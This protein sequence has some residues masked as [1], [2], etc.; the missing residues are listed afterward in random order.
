MADTVLVAFGLLGTILFV[1]F[2]GE[3]VFRKF[4]IPGVLLLL[5]TGFLLS[6]GG[7]QYVDPSFD[8]A[9]LASYRTLLGP[10]TLMVIL[11][12]GGMLLNIYTVI[13]QSV[14]PF[15]FGL[16]IVL[17][18]AGATALIAHYLFR[19]DMMAG[20]LL[21]VM[22]SGSSPA[23]TIP[24]ASKLK[25]PDDAKTFIILEPSFTDVLCAVLV[26]TVTAM[27]FTNTAVSA[28]DT[29]KELLSMFSIG[30]V[31]GAVG[32]VI[33]VALLSRIGKLTDY[34]YMATLAVLLFMFVF[35]EYFG[36][37]GYIAAIVFGLVLGNR[38]EIDSMLK[39]EVEHTGDADK[40][41]P[42]H[43]EISFFLRTIFFT[44]LGMIVNLGSIISM[45]PISVAIMAALVIARAIAT[46]LS[47]LGSPI[48]KFNNLISAFSD[49]G[50]S[51]AV[52]STYPLLYVT[53]KSPLFSTVK[54]FPDIA[55]TI[56]ILA[57]IVSTIGI[58]LTKP[59]N[60]TEVMEPSVKI[61]KP[62][63]N[64]A[65]KERMREALHRT[66]GNGAKRQ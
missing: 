62:E 34:I 61:S 35:V 24:V 16:L 44:Y 18:T 22:L 7:I 50:L 39:L 5:L 11:F 55:F 47:T 19:I 54:Q 32:G 4:E 52:L 9:S 60:G 8:A 45:L 12:D 46:R 56:I 48:S 10:L 42:F 63:E 15:L 14:R 40:L 21:G 31:V 6:H 20:V 23:I 1:G 2:A 49:R 38:H 33:W 41:K 13:K 17:F 30:A 57:A 59:K 66:L 43:A 53:D 28:Q 29:G 65:E 27:M 51:V 26:I 64:D 36:A 25:I 3:L 37:S 58:A